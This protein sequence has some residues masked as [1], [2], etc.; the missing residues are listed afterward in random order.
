MKEFLLRGCA[1]VVVGLAVSLVPAPSRAKN[2]PNSDEVR[3]QAAE[4][5]QTKNTFATY[6]S[7]ADIHLEDSGRS[8]FTW[9]IRNPFGH[10]SSH[11]T[12]LRFQPDGSPTLTWGSI[13]TAA[14]LTIDLQRGP[15]ALLSAEV[16]ISKRN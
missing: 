3:P 1:L 8:G 6:P 15:A 7:Q 4:V 10:T 2:G 11:P 5:G 12:W 16:D 13:W 9:Y 14:R